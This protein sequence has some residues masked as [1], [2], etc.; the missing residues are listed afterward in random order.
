[1]R[2][3]A[4]RKIH[5]HTN[6]IVHLLLFCSS[7]R[8][9]LVKMGTCSCNY[10]IS[11]IV[12]FWVRL[13]YDCNKKKM[14]N[15]TLFQTDKGLSWVIFW[16]LSDWNFFFLIKCSSCQLQAM[17]GPVSHHLPGKKPLWCS[18]PSRLSQRREQENPKSEGGC[19]N[20]VENN[21]W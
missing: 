14:V 10:S 11:E 18:C 9:Y 8:L 21:T 5:K 3:F 1:M 20:I 16:C 4:K 2:Y 6:R 17:G 13:F 12:Q 15:K 7:W 19:W